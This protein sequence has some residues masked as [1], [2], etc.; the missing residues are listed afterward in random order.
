ML[1]MGKRVAVVFKVKTG[2]LPGTHTHKYPLPKTY[3][4]GGK[5]YKV[6]NGDA[7]DLRFL[8]PQGV[9]VGLRAK[10][11]ARNDATGFVLDATIEP[12]KLVA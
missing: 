6:I 5:R 7:N 4:I 12:I 3:A 11:K 2:Y 9:I 8:D 1:G 10:G